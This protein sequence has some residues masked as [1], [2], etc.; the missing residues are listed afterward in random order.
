[1]SRIIRKY[2]NNIRK[3]DG[4]RPMLVTVG[5][6]AVFII[7]A[8]CL[9]GGTK[10]HAAGYTQ[11][12]TDRLGKAGEVYLDLVD[13]TAIQ[14]TETEEMNSEETN[15][16]KDS[17]EESNLNRSLRKGNIQKEIR[18]PIGMFLYVR[19]EEYGATLPYYDKDGNEIGRLEHG[20]WIEVLASEDTIA[21]FYYNENYDIA[22]V[23]TSYL[24]E[25]QPGRQVRPALEPSLSPEE[26]GE[27]SIHIWK[28][29]RELEL[30]S[31]GEVIAIYTIGLG[32]WPWDTKNVKG[33]SRTP[34]GSYYI[35]VR[36]ASSRFH[37]SLGL[38]YPNKEDAQRGYEN[39]VINKKQKRA[40]ENAIDAGQQPPWNTGLGGEIMIHG[41]SEDGIGA[42]FDWTAGCIA[43]EDAVID[44]LWKYCKI[45]TEVMIDP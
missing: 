28:E 31:D 22:Y 12:M 14:E 40:I 6:L 41:A 19:L 2:L 4:Q 8:F 15:S 36:N 33:D 25:E 26:A 23:D 38:S 24:T 13:N 43:V 7:T 11:L 16:E 44:I 18:I 32:G 1:M 42:E 34:E 30:L 29:R 21:P 20:A 35:C 45:G 3:M 27:I 5:A 39:G 9:G 17:R 37:L 10:V